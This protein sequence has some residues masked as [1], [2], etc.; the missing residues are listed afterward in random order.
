[1][2]ESDAARDPLTIF[3]AWLIS[4]GHA[5]EADIKKIQDEVDATVLAA[6]DDALSQPQPAPES[7]SFGVYSPSVNPCGEQFD[8][9][10]DPQFNGEPTTMVDLLNACLKDEMR[11]DER[12]VLFGEDVADVSRDTNLGKVKG[13]GGVFKVT[14]G[15]QKEFGSTRV[16]NSPLAEANIVG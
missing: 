8:T 12:I 11:R 13:K 6:T 1:E 5:T 14:W 9:E 16:F 2:R 4:E 7:V 10:D 15:L 3:P